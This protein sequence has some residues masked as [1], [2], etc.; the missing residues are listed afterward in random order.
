LQTITQHTTNQT[1]IISLQ[2]GKSKAEISLLNGGAL[3]QLIIDEI[4]IIEDFS[5]KIDYKQSYASSILFPFANRILD[6]KYEY[7]NQKHQLNQNAA[8][9]TNAIHG[10]IYNKPFKVI[11]KKYNL[12]S[13]SVTLA[14]TQKTKQKGFPFLFSI[15][16]TYTLFENDIS[17]KVTI[18]NIDD[19]SFPF[20]VG[21]HPYFY[22]EDRKSSI[23]KINSIKEIIHNDKMIPIKTEDSKLPNHFKI[24]NQ[25]FDNC[26]LLKDDSV[27]FKTPNY[28]LKL[29]SSFD[30]NYIQIYTPELDNHIAI[31][32]ITGPSNSFNN[33]L[34]LKTLQPKEV[35]N[36]QWT[37][38]LKDE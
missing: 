23:I 15:L 19:K 38:Q 18:N 27:T 9:S 8:S 36:I 29:R 28:S 1:S 30:K 35:F 33:N 3:T 22:S 37:I 24:G 31:E 10:L 14:Y 34:G 4:T 32:P 25:K 5:K 2:K 20:T 17:L 6:G 21:W 12:N 11:D 16:L 26:Y 7:L 13:V